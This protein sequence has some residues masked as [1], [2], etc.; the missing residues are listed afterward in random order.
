MVIVCTKKQSIDEQR[1]VLEDHFRNITWIE[2]PATNSFREID[3]IQDTIET[4]ISETLST[5]QD[6]SDVT[7]LLS[8]GPMGK[9]LA[10]RLSQRGIQ[11]L[12]IGHGFET[13]YT[14]DDRFEKLLV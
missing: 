6:F 10:Y 5:G 12:D 3:N 1:P 4:R 13:L 11:C 2:A 7:V 9:V 8:T 14:N